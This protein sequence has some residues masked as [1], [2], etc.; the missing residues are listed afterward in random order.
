M[1]QLRKKYSRLLGAA[2]LICMCLAMPVYAQEEVDDSYFNSTVFVGDSISLKLRDYVYQQ[3][4]TD[5]GF[6]GDA[7][8]L[9]VGGLGSVSVQLPITDKSLH[10]T[11]NGQKRMLEDSIS[12]MDVTKLYIMFGM[13]DI[14]PYGVEGAAANLEAL[15][16]K[17]LAKSPGLTVAVQSVTPILPEREKRNLNNAII[18]EYNGLLK[19]LCDRRGFAYLDINTVL[20]APSGGLQLSYCG[21]ASSMG[22]HLSNEGC[23][24]WVAYL[25]THPIDGSNT[26]STNPDT[27]PLPL[28][29][30][31]AVYVSY[32]E[33]RHEDIQTPGESEAGDPEPADQGIPS[34]TVEEMQRILLDMENDNRIRGTAGGR[35]RG[36]RGIFK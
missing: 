1:K 32:E 3:R 4:E 31:A 20:Q 28:P 36:S 17:I 6:L 8:F 9:T 7:Q 15:I 24:P 10:P 18:A 2:I 30:D 25:R 26:N 29:E 14:I 22:M 12:Q 11:Y 21:D 23:E 34:M 16:D 19:D 27:I 13:N 33:V 35:T 5:P